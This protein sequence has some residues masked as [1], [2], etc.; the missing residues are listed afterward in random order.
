MRGE[1]VDFGRGV[2]EGILRG[3]LG[4]NFWK[5]IWVGEGVLGEFDVCFGGVFG[6]NGNFRHQNGFRS[7]K[8][9]AVVLCSRSCRKVVQNTPMG[10]MFSDNSYYFFDEIFAQLKL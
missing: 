8:K 5:G 10:F 7:V 1:G 9:S 4:W 2:L 3:I 6:E